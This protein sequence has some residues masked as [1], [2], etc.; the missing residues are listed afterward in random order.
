MLCRIKAE[1]VNSA[2]DTFFKQS[3]SRLLNVTV[4]CVQVGHT[5][6]ILSYRV[7]AVITGFGVIRVIVS[8]VFQTAVY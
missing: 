5:E 4:A 7:S 6:M 1:A 8:T 2:V 3:Q